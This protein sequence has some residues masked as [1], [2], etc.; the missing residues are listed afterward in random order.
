MRRKAP[1]CLPSEGAKALGSRDPGSVASAPIVG[2]GQGPQETP[3]APR[4]IG[5]RFRYPRYTRLRRRSFAGT[6]R[7]SSLQWRSEERGH[8]PLYVSELCL[9]TM[10]FNNPST[11]MGQMLGGTGQEL[12]TRM[13][14]LA[15]DAGV[16]FFDTA[17]VY[18][19]GESEEMLGKALGERRKDKRVVR[20][21]QR[22]EEERNNNIRESGSSSAEAAPVILEA[23]GYADPS[24]RRRTRPRHVHPRSCRTR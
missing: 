5:L 9:G 13:V 1:R 24:E 17:N 12:A 16:N 19:F 20:E 11:P 18:G 6:R 8:G 21:R 22:L 15:L 14:D 3:I 23:Y 7:C 2:L 10:T 4:S